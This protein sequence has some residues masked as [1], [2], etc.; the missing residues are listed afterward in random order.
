MKSIIVLLV[1]SLLTAAVPSLAADFQ[2]VIHS[3]RPEA[4]IS[5]VDLSRIFLKKTTRWAEGTQIAPIDQEK[6]YSVR[7]TFL[8]EIH[9]HDENAYAKY[10][11][12]LIF[13]GRAQPPEIV[14]GDEAVLNAVRADP[15]AIGYVSTG[16][17]LPADVKTLDIAD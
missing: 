5:K 11:V 7:E 1:S 6:G 13:S 12:K 14:S 2:V 15:A 8:S 4:S 17:T 10:W 9:D 3:E 16:T